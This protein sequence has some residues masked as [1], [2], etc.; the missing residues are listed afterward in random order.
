MRL[1]SSSSLLLASLAVSASSSSSLSALAA[2]AGDLPEDSSSPAPIAHCR[3]GAV[4]RSHDQPQS[5]GLVDHVSQPLEQ[6][7]EKLKEDITRLTSVL[8][9]RDSESPAAGDSNGPE[10]PPAP[11]STPAVPPPKPPVRPPVPPPKLPIGQRS[12]IGGLGN[13]VREA[14][15][16][17]RSDPPN[18][19]A[20]PGADE[21]PIIG[22]IPKPALP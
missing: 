15:S 21:L 16:P 18:T 20:Q 17:T 13:I 2:P 19:P 11:P 14:L 22:E 5:R 8:S 9:T 7:V 1:P 4:T 3:D 12:S 10:S 6:A